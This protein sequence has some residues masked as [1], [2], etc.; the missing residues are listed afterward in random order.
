MSSLKEEMNAQA[1]ET[2]NP[3][4]VLEKLKIGASKIR[5]RLR[6]KQSRAAPEEAASKP[7]SPPKKKSQVRQKVS[8]FLTEASDSFEKYGQVACNTHYLGY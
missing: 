7:S 5:A 6:G 2:S 3:R 1:G 4:T 8:R